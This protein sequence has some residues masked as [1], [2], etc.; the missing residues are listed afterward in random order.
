MKILTIILLTAFGLIF[1]PQKV[2]AQGSEYAVDY[3]YKIKWGHFKEFMD[4]YKK[5]HYPILAKMQAQ[6]QIVSMAAVYPLN[7]GAE[8]SRWDFRF[9]IVFKDFD[10][11]HNSDASAQLTQELYP[12]QETFKKEE[13]RRFQ[14]LLEHLDIPLDVDDLEEW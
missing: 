11:A 4:L 3:Y 7:H 1:L 5:N 9:T 13:Q 2:E 6:G 8:A 10:A 12:D 14:L